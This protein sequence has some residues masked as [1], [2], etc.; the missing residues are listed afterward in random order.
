M[1]RGI[2]ILILVLLVLATAAYFATRRGSGEIVLTG[3]V[4]TDEVIV[5]SELQGRL[6]E[7]LVN[8]GDIVK[9]NQLL[10]LIQPQEWKADVAF[11][12][13]SEQQSVA[14]VAQTEADLKYQEIQTTNQIRQAEANLAASQ[15]QVTQAQADLELAKLNSQREE[16]LFKRGVEPV[17]AYD[18]S[19]TAYKAAKA[20]VESLEKQAQAAEAAVS[21]AQGNLEQVAARRA[22]VDASIRQLAA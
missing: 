3:I 19:R 12:S 18:Q 7:L 4:T 9:S 22:A 2:P 11:Y 5:S 14:Q 20:R 16:G 6:Q 1:R 10:A 21:L 8:Q 17:Q 13:S 15:A